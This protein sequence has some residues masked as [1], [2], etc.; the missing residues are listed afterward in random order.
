LQSA[1]ARFEL[2]SHVLPLC[3]QAAA[4]SCAAGLLCLSAATDSGGGGSREV[5]V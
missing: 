2:G 4:C 3:L 5:A 1:A